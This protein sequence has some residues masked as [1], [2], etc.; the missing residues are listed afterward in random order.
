MSA[1]PQSR[2]DRLT[3]PYTNRMK[4]ARTTLALSSLG[5]LLLGIAL[6]QFSLA[7]YDL[8]AI[9]GTA[10]NPDFARGKV[11]GCKDGYPGGYGSGFSADPYKPSIYCAA[12][13]TGT[14]D[15]D[16]GKSAG[17]NEFY[18]K[19]Y[20]AGDTDLMNDQDSVKDCPA[21]LK[22]TTGTNPGAYDFGCS[23][24]YVAGK[25]GSP[26][27]WYCTSQYQTFSDEYIVGCAAGHQKGLTDAAPPS[28]APPVYTS[29]HPLIVPFGG[30]TSRDTP[31]G[32]YLN[33]VYRWSIG[34]AAL[35]AVF[36][37]AY[38]GVL[39]ILSA[40]SIYS[41]E[42]ATGK[43]KSA[44]TGLLLLLSITL[45]LNVINPN[46]TFVNPDVTATAPW[47]E[48]VATDPLGTLSSFSTVSTV[49]SP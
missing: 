41:Q 10:V 11:S 4:P 46:L 23:D 24:G 22:R 28:S 5:I 1:P 13:G 42:E 47:W 2:L 8:N 19:G 14:T 18:Q 37:I 15:F 49:L 21:S 34:L 3:P 17:C 45:I 9:C 38:G 20:L 44:I 7:Y 27:P 16:R 48:R 35:L 25:S 36:Q 33:A 32:D 29:D 43:M 12:S 31:I 30:L 39:Y 40:G 26:L 6:P